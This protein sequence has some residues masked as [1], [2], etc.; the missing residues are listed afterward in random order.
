[1]EWQGSVVGL[2]L[3]TLKSLPNRPPK[4]GTVVCPPAELENPKTLPSL[5]EPAPSPLTVPLICIFDKLLTF[6]GGECTVMAGSG[7]GAGSTFSKVGG[8]ER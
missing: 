6:S 7:A 3:N 1:M 2:L 4:C 5:P 8:R